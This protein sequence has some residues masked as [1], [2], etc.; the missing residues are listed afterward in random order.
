MRVPGA[1]TCGQIGPVANRNGAGG[2]GD[3]YSHRMVRKQVYI[4]PDQ[5]RF[6]K[7]RASEL[8]IAEA[9]LIRQAVDLLAQTAAT[10][11]FAPEAWA[12]EEA[13][14]DRR[15]HVH[16]EQSTWRFRREVGEDFFDFV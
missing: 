1:F 11:T 12:D 14:L 15:A 3:V 9:D 6:L 13:M 7:R 10:Q 5:E 16:A 4:R 8:G 2:S